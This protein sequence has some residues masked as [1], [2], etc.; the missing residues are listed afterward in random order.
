MLMKAERD[1]VGELL[2]GEAELSRGSMGPDPHR[3][4]RRQN[5]LNGLWKSLSS[6]SGRGWAPMRPE[7][8]I[9][10]ICWESFVDVLIHHCR[11]YVVDSRR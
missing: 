9:F 6:H 5:F 3:W 4:G 2:A 7:W 8:E 1:G 10:T 11:D